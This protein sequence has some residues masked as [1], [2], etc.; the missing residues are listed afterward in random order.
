M[1]RVSCSYCAG[2]GTVQLAQSLEQV[3]EAV[4]RSRAALL[5][6]IGAVLKKRKT[7]MGAAELTSRLAKLVHHGLLFRSNTDE[8]YR[9][10]RASE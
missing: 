2:A 4:P 7:P 8:G 1:V 3:L 5:R 10:E 9:W 6:E